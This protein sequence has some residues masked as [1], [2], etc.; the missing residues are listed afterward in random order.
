MG[1]EGGRGVRSKAEKAG[2]FQKRAARPRPE[3]RGGFAPPRGG[4]RRARGEVARARGA[5]GAPGAAAHMPAPVMARNT[6]LERAV[7]PSTRVA[8][9][10]SGRAA[11]REASPEARTSAPPPDRGC[12][13]RSRRAP[14]PR[15][16]AVGS[17]WKNRGRTP[18]RGPARREQAA[19]RGTVPCG[20]SPNHP[21]RLARGMRGGAG[22]R[23]RT[24]ASARALLHAVRVTFS[25]QPARPPGPLGEARTAAKQ[26]R[27]PRP[28]ELRRRR[29]RRGRRRSAGTRRAVACR[30]RKGWLRK[31]ARDGPSAAS[32]SRP[33]SWA[34]EEH[35]AGRGPP[36]NPVHQGGM[37]GRLCRPSR[38]G[39]DEGRSTTVP[40]LDRE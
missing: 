16:G 32:G 14:R 5:R 23:E 17:R 34:A 28:L 33:M 38:F 40:C 31:V 3:H 11:L 39:A 12:P 25:V 26:G 27:R 24:A 22:G 18:A 37:V 30:K 13:I 9:N 7:R 15:G 1:L 21:A 2:R 4:A 8:G 10:S 19:Q 29:A 36:A 20:S 35:G 6:E